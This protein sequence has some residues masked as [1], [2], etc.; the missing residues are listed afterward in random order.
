M[1]CASFDVLWKSYHW[2]SFSM[3]ACRLKEASITFFMIKGMENL[4]KWKKH[5]SGSYSEFEMKTMAKCRTGNKTY[6]YHVTSSDFYYLVFSTNSF[7]Y[8]ILSVDISTFLSY[9]V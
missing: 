8:S 2:V 1:S 9:T 4:N 6:S 5:K 7:S 3:P